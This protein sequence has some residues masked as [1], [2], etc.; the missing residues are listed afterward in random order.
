MSDIRLRMK[1]WLASGEARLQPLTL[2]QRELWEASAVPA[3]HPSNHI[4]SYIR[5]VGKISPAR[6]QAAI[7]RVVDRQESL[8][9]SILPGKTQALQ[10]IRATHEANFRIGEPDPND[11]EAAMQRV[12]EE[13]F[14]LVKGPLYRIEMMQSKPNEW[15]LVFAIHH[16]IADGWSLGV[17]V[18]D[19]AA[20][21][22]QELRRDRNPSVVVEPTY[23]Q[24]GAQQRAFWDEEKL[25]KAARFWTEHLAGSRTLYDQATDP[26][27]L[28]RWVTSFPAKETAAIKRLARQTGGTLFS[29]LLTSFR[30]A[31]GHWAKATDFVIGSPIA[32]RSMA[33]S[34]DTMGYFADNLPLRLQLDPDQPFAESAQTVFQTVLKAMENPMPFAEIARAVGSTV[35]GENPIFDVRFALQNHPVPRVTLPNLLAELTMR[36]TGTAR[37]ELGCEITE[38]KGALEVVWLFKAARFDRKELTTLDQLFRSILKAA[39]TDPNTCPFP[40]STPGQLTTA[41]GPVIAPEPI[42]PHW[43]SRSAF[44]IIVFCLLF[45]E[46]G[47]G[48]AVFH[49][50]YWVAVPLVIAASHF[51]HGLLIGFHEASHGMLRENRRFNEFDGVFIGILSLTSFSLYRVSHQTHHMHLASEKDEELWPFVH[52]TSPRWLRCLAAFLE[53]NFGLFYTPSIFFRTFVRKNSPIR[54]AKV[55]G[56]IWK[57]CAGA[58]LFWTLLLTLVA[59]LDA[60]KYLLWLYFIPAFISANLQ[61]WRKYIEH[62]G[63]TGCTPNSATRSI[64]CRSLAGRLVAFSLLHEPFHGVHHED[65]SF[66]HSE[67]PDHADLLEPKAPEDVP[68]F[69]SYFA[70]FLHLFRCLMNPKVGSQWQRTP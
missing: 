4:C 54:N 8:R 48:F 26:S 10:L 1:D 30:L 65:T 70:A 53:L 29:T 11:V 52:P 7:Q 3:D 20:A 27:T 18:Q 58:L 23:S 2:P 60:W 49:S 33:D 12:F 46:I 69:P 36:S 37:F 15:L 50:W 55:R 41:G 25:E 24:W 56:R 42:E 51:M 5:V 35:P 6:C 39:A 64:V 44:Q 45:T 68:P 61:S 38:T 19:L 34:Q 28:T 22:L 9:T 43:A 66:K 67:L 47:L 62:V 14:D 59:F 40:P 16:A 17:F 31:L 63:M 13:P 32:N 21:Y 57:E